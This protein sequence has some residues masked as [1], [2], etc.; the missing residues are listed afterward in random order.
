MFERIAKAKQAAEENQAHAV[1]VMADWLARVACW[2][3]LR[4]LRDNHS[5]AKAAAVTRQ[6][7]AAAQR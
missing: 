3:C 6:R 2:R 7:H 1:E 4:P 5:S